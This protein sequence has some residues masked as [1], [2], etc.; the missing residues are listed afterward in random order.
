MNGQQS[1]PFQVQVESIALLSSLHQF[2]TSHPFI[3]TVRPNYHSAI[4]SGCKDGAILFITVLITWKDP[5]NL[6]LWSAM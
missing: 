5:I 2:V 4:I 6:S 1:I 3:L